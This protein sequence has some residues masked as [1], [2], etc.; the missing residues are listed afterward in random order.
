V[1]KAIVN[2][3]KPIFM[4]RRRVMPFGQRGRAQQK[5]EKPPPGGNSSI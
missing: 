5:Q 2:S 4:F 1:A 3:Q